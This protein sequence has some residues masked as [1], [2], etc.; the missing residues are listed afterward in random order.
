MPFVL[1]KKTDLICLK[2]SKTFMSTSISIRKHRSKVIN[3]WR[4]CTWSPTRIGL[5]IACCGK[6]TWAW[7]ETVELR[8]PPVGPMVW[9]STRT[10]DTTARYWGKSVQMMRTTGRSNTFSADSRS[11][12]NEREQLTA[13]GDTWHY[14]RYGVAV[15]RHTGHSVMPCDDIA[16]LLDCMIFIH[17]MW[18]NCSI[19]CCLL[20]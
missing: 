12:Y 7:G 4:R 6:T 9:D 1:Y 16:S 5:T 2:S 14:G 13:N 11:V 3:K 18:M 19:S 8:I 15:C 20:R 17:R 10:R